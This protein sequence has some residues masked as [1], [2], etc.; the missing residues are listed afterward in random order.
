MRAPGP[1][2]FPDLRS[3]PVQ[4]STN[5]IMSQNHPLL[6]TMTETPRAST[7]KAEPVLIASEERLVL[8]P[9]RYPEVP[10]V[11]AVFLMSFKVMK[12]GF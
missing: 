6:T 8:W 9:I 11:D 4:S 1:R 10:F 5:T 2:F 12:I 7:Y 3:F